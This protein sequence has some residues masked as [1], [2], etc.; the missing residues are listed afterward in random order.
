MSIVY[1]KF[2]GNLNNQQWGCDRMWGFIA[3][4]TGAFTRS[5]AKYD[6]G[7]EYKEQRSVNRNGVVTKLDADVLQMFSFLS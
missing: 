5:W 3:T 4:F 7:C 6:P 2:Y 1:P